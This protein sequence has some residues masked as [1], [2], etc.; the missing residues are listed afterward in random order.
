MGEGKLMA[1]GALVAFTAL[2]AGASIMR[3]VQANS[4]YTDQGIAMMKQAQIAQFESDYAAKQKQ[5]EVDKAAARQVMAMSKNGL[6]TSA[7][8]PLEVLYETMTLGQEEVE[9][10]KRQGAAQVDM[11]KANANTMFNNGR[12]ELLGGA[13]DA[14]TSIGTM[15]IGGSANGLFKGGGAAAGS[16]AGGSLTGFIPSIS[17]AG[18][19]ASGYM[20]TL[21]KI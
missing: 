15:F 2:S 12:S 14:L 19:S 13:T 21:P 1:T 8:S 18:S 6:V 7:G 20:G 9:A 16:A 5:R 3:G 17:S 4:A 11:Y 10:I